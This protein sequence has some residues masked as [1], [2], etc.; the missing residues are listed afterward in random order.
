MNEKYRQYFNVTNDK[1]LIDRKTPT[2]QDREI[3][4]G[5][6][7]LKRE[8][9]K[10]ALSGMTIVFLISAII[11]IAMNNIWGL[12][13]ILFFGYLEYSIARDFITCR[14]WEIEYCDYGSVVD[15]FIK[16]DKDDSDKKYYLIVD[17]NGN[18]LKYKLNYQEFCELNISD[19]VTIF[20]IKEKKETFVAKS[21]GTI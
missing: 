15:K 10:K 17:A 6:I 13:I 19:T 3:F 14:N 1:N 2:E 4:C 5:A 12:I 9:F 8:E 11:G 16:A 21:N 7:E 18:N 20:A